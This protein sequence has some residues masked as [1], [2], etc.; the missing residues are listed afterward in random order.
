MKYFYNSYTDI[1]GRADNEDSMCIIESPRGLLLIVADGLGGCDSGELASSLVVEELKKSFCEM[2]NDFN[3]S[4]SINDANS[5]ICSVQA[6]KKTKM[7]T[8]VAAAWISDNQTILAHVGDS[9]I[10][11]LQNGKIVYQSLDH[12][13]SQLA[14]SVGEI[15]ISQI[16]KHVDRNILIRALGV[17]GPIKVDVKVK[18][19]HEYDSI[20]LCSDGFWEYVMEDEIMDFR[21]SSDTCGDWLKKMREVLSVRIPPN[22]DNNTA[23]VLVKEK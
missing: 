9:R 15:D 5:K 20:L 10:Y 3:L 14:V 18:N 17:P 13:A 11:A 7:K 4:D 21:L 16:R 2:D 23:I 22:N 6:E 8:T 1:G 12:S 19:N